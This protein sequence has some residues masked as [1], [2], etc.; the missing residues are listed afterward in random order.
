MLQA[1][2]WNSVSSHRTHELANSS[3]SSLLDNDGITDRHLTSD[4]GINDWP[5]VD[6]ALTEVEYTDVILFELSGYEVVKKT[7]EQSKAMQDNYWNRRR[8]G[9][10]EKGFRRFPSLKR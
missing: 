6:D 5:A 10:R 2:Y 4:S 8:R 1:T 9:I 3:S 7:I